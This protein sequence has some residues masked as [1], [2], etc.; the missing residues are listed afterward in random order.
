MVLSP[1][2]VFCKSEAR[3]T[4]ASSYMK[5]QSL[6]KSHGNTWIINSNT[7]QMQ[8]VN[9]I[10]NQEEIEETYLAAKKKNKTNNPCSHGKGK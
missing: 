3:K 2:Y 1:Q 10:Y 8:G 9:N 4:N 7:T 6:F 5:S